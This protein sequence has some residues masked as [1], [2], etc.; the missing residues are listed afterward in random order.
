MSGK[1]LYNQTVVVSSDDT[2]H[3]RFPNIFVDYPLGSMRVGNKL[4]TNWSKAPLRLWQTQ[5]NFLCGVHRVVAGLV[6]S[7]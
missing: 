6:P 7:I 5:L 3:V 4:W 2:F 1:G